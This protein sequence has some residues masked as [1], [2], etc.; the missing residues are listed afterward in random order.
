M[1][2]FTLC[3]SLLL[4]LFALRSIAYNIWVHKTTILLLG[5]LPLSS[6]SD[7]F[8]QHIVLFLF[9]WQFISN[10]LFLTL[11]SLNISNNHIRESRIVFMPRGFSGLVNRMPVLPVMIFQSYNSIIEVPTDTF[12]SVSP[13]IYIRQSFHRLLSLSWFNVATSVGFN[14]A[15]KG[16]RLNAITAW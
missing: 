7:W 10:C 5:N 13:Y 14:V 4:Q 9:L 8:L 15:S 2:Y 11:F 3:E 16:Q 6:K 12:L 1:S